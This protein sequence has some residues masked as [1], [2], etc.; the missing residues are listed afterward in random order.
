[1]KGTLRACCI[2]IFDYDST[3]MINLDKMVTDGV[4]TYVVYQ[5]EIAPETKK[6]HI[7]GYVEF[8]NPVRWNK[9]KKILGID[10]IHIEQRH[11]TPKEASDYCKKADSRAPD[12]APKE[13]GTLSKGQGSRNDL[14]A[15]KMDLDSG[16]TEMQIADEHFTPW[17]KYHKAFTRYR[18]L[19]AI[20]RTAMSTS[21]ILWGESDCGKTRLAFNMFGDNVSIAPGNCGVWYD[22][23]QQEEA[24]IFDE[25]K[26]YIKFGDFKRVIDSYS[27]TVD[28]KGGQREFNSR[29][30]V[31]TSNHDPRVDWYDRQLAVDQ[32]AYERRLH[33]VLEA[34]KSVTTKSTFCRVTKC[35]LPWN[36][37]MRDAWALPG[38]THNESLR[39][40]NPDIPT[41]EKKD[42]AKRCRIVDPLQSHEVS[43]SAG[44]ILHPALLRGA[45]FYEGAKHILQ[46]VLFNTEA[47]NEAAAQYAPDD[48]EPSDATVPVPNFRSPDLIT[49]PAPQSASAGREALKRGFAYSATYGMP[50]STGRGDVWPPSQVYHRSDVERE[51]QHPDF[52]VSAYYNA[53]L[54]PQENPRKKRLGSR[55]A[56][57]PT[58]VPLPPYVDDDEQD[59]SCGASMEEHSVGDYESDDWIIDDIN[60]PTQ[61][62]SKNGEPQSDYIKRL[63]RRMR[64]T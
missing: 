39:L 44:V 9:I 4:A 33:I 35:V 24:C 53:E 43:R 56:P 29:F 37:N 54:F 60:K 41:A 17:C 27:Y 21:V 42:I 64:T 63:A 18:E 19:K 8:A 49:P 23:Y 25:F 7:Q 47:L 48:D 10:S 13:F 58:P 36:A 14:A 57:P 1:M 6:P 52:G 28:T 45:P 15:V 38:I 51:T 34:A 30:I 55:V 16:A 50:N 2:T 20:K 31:F 40:L 11:G 12:T 61:W 3:T 32:H 5:Q 62:V 22:K 46:Q 26:N 59:E